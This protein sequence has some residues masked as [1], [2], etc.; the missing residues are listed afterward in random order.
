MAFDE[1]LAE[2]VRTALGT[3]PGVTER[4]MF[5]GLAFLYEGNMA[6]GVIGD[7]LMVRVGPEATEA[8]LARP[9]ARPFDFTGRPMRGWVLVAP[10]AVSE[11]GA[12]ADWI[13]RGRGFAASLPPK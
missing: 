5:G 8:A 11:D 13:E 3:D 10:S 1:G 6:V 9:G 7:E 12:L 4:R 2:R